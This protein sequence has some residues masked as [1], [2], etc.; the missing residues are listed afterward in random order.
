MSSTTMK[1]EKTQNKKRS[2]SSSLLSKIDILKKRMKSE[3]IKRRV[4]VSNNSDCKLNDLN[5]P[6]VPKPF[7]ADVAEI[8]QLNSNEHYQGKEYEEIVDE[9]ELN[10]TEEEIW[11]DEEQQ[12]FEKLCNKLKN[13]KK[14]FEVLKK[15]FPEKNHKEIV[16]NYYVVYQ[17][18][19]RSKS[20]P[21]A[22]L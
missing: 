6:D 7:L 10:S 21:K 3:E 8:P 1:N 11:T 14:K 22:L 19:K 20:K 4:K 18:V 17:P 13:N 12:K 9:E 15:Q 16:H 2:L 5:P